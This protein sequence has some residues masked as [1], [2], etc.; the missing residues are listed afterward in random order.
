MGE[1]LGDE[2][3]NWYRRPEGKLA[4]AEAE[5]DSDPD[6]GLDSGS[7]ARINSQSTSAAVRLNLPVLYN[8]DILACTLKMSSSYPRRVVT[9]A[10]A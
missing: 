7:P 4:D 1:C 3:D 6:S 5:A 8:G 10:M 2:P 9:G